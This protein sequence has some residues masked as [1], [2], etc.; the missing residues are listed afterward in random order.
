MQLTPHESL[1]Y[2]TALLSLATLLW[3]LYESDGDPGH[4]QAAIDAWREGCRRGRDLALS[5]AL[6]GTLNWS[7][8]MISGQNWVTAVEASEAGLDAADALYRLQLTRDNQSVWLEEANPLPGLAAYALAKLGRLQEAVAVIE[9]GR[10]VF[11]AEYLS[12]GQAA[13][14]MLADIGFAEVR[15]SYR[16]AADKVA[17]LEAAAQQASDEAN[18]AAAQQHRDAVRTA[19]PIWTG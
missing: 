19:G 13:L 6:Q 7:E 9:R 15:D 2:G 17:Q 12:R 10:A 16:E 3:K 4:A 11:F 18:F 14:A 5:Q 1:H 8:A